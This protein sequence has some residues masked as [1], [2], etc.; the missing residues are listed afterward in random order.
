MH[1]YDQELGSVFMDLRKQMDRLGE[2]DKDLYHSS[3]MFSES[4]SRL[5][6]IMMKLQ[7]KEDCPA[8]G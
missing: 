3:R 4:L 2:R 5:E 1:K 7:D 8:G 6:D